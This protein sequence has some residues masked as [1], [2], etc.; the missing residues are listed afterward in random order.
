PASAKVVRLNIE[1]TGESIG[2]I[3]GAGD[4]V[5]ESLRQIGYQV[6]LLDPNNISVGTLSKYDAVVIGIRAYN[7]LDKLKF[8]QPILMDYV[9]NGGNLIVQY[10]T[11]GRNDPG[12]DQLSPYPL[13]LSRDRV[14]DENSP[15]KILD[16]KNSLVNF[17]NKI[18]QKDFEGWVQ[19]RGLY[20][21]NIWGKEFTP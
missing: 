2:Y 15:V 10:N 21:Q 18:T 11:A 9:Q 7:V 13:T 14:T 5:P 17:P 12:L 16:P 19:E 20:F 8:K 4:E 6:Q 3:M 1:K